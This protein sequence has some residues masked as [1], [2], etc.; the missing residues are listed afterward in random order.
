MATKSAS[1]IAP[2]NSS[3]SGKNDPKSSNL[4]RMPR[5]LAGTPAPD[6]AAR[7]QT[8]AMYESALKLMQSGKY[9]KAHQAFTQML[10]TAPQ[11]LADRIRVYIAACV[12]QI[13]KGS[14]KFESNEERYDYAISLLN[15]GQYDDARQHF[16]QILKQNESA[17][18]AF[19]GLALLASM[20]GDTQECI[21]KLREAIRLNGQNRL[22]A[23]ADS[24]FETVAEDPRF[25]ELLY[26]EA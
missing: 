9:D 3:H 1:P 4:R 12:S 26:P 16:E 20:T 7:K 21:D 6:D 22:Q 19:Y 23:R 10:Q 2:S 11:D 15:Q 8:L 25:T 5:T 18:Y 14:T 17:D 24:D 13:E